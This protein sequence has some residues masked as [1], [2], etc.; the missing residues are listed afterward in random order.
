MTGLHV[1][2][3]PQEWEDVIGQ[4][5]AVKSMRSVIKDKAASTFLLIGPSGVGK[6]TLARIA[7]R[8]LGASRDAIAAGEIN[9]ATNTGVDDMRKVQE[10][11]NYLPFDSPVRPL[12]VD[13]C[14]RLS[15]QAWDSLLKITE[16]PPD[17]VYWFF[18]TTNP[19][20]VPATIKTRA[21][22]VVLSDLSIKSLGDLYDEIAEKEKFD[23]PGDVADFI[24]KE[25]DGSARMLLVNMAACRGVT[26]RRDAAKIL[27]KVV[28]SDAVLNFCRVISKGPS[29]AAAMAAFAKLDDEEPESVRIVVSNYLASCLRKSTKE[30]D[31]IYFLNL[32]E[33][34]A[35]PYNQAAGKAGLFRSIG[36]VVYPD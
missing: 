36:K 1:K 30:S 19:N 10:L 32:L 12:I 18:C 13:E 7:A 22:K 29:W 16:E 8:K 25:S 2:Y 28:D 35:E 34:F 6:T 24:I 5:A 21:H 14:H 17:F 33:A 4:D 31:A 9:A 11:A 15:Q 26:S 20:K 3:R 27:Q 23:I